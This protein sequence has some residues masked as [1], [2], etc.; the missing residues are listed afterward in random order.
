MYISYTIKREFPFQP[1]VQISLNM[2]SYSG[3]LTNNELLTVNTSHPYF[4]PI[5][6]LPSPSNLVASA[7]ATSIS[8]TWEQPQGADA[9]DSY[10]INY[11]FTVDECT[12]GGNF[13]P[14]TVMV[15]DG[16]LRRYT[17]IKSSTTPV[18]EDSTYFI[19]LIALNSLARS[20]ATT[21][22]GNVTTDTAGVLYHSYMH[23]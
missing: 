13:P 14:V 12:G 15:A 17:I 9:V 19:S 11:N 16:S 1:S 21:I 2:H 20:T 3:L 5:A 8:L 18:E 4:Y 7:L 6:P 22:S 10:E 23:D